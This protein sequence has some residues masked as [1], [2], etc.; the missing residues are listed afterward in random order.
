MAELPNTVRPDVRPDAPGYRPLSG[1]ALA[2][3]I[4]SGFGAVLVT[5]LGI[6]AKLSSKPVLYPSVMLVPVIGIALAVVAQ[7]QLRRAEGSRVGAGLARAGLW[8]G[9]LFGAGYAAYYFFTAIAVRQQARGA[10]EQ[11]LN[12]LKQNEPEL[13]F[14]LTLAPGQQLTIAEDDRAGIRRRFG[15]SELLAFERTDLVRTCL[16]WHDKMNVE[17]QGV[18]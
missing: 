3:L 12:L 10:A 4:V 16:R 18:R 9:I 13:A 1:P 2:A 15:A 17:P 14:R 7:W 5:I 11:F 6:A 8:L